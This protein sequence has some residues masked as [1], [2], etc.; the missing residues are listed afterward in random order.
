MNHIT[1]IA[2]ARPNFMKV[3]P[4]IQEKIKDAG[5]FH[6]DSFNKEAISIDTEK[7]IEVMELLFTEEEIITFKK[8]YHEEISKEKSK[9]N[10]NRL[11]Q[12]I[13]DWSGIAFGTISV[14]S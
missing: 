1:I 4:I 3:A 13:K 6:D 2:G 10:R 14:I 7:F 8:K 5:L 11:L 9:R 12:E